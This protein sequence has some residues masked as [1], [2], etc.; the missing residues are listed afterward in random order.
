MPLLLLLLG[1]RPALDPQ[2]ATWLEGFRFSWKYFNHR[3]STLQ[4][5]P[6]SGAL[7]VAVVGGTSTTG[8]VPEALPAGCEA[9]CEEFPFKDDAL[10]HADWVRVRSERAALV[11]GAATFDVGREGAGG[12]LS[13]ALPKGARGDAV[14]VIEG[15]RLT[16]DHPLAGDEA[17][18]RPRYGWHPRRLAV[19]LGE[20]VVEDDTV[21]VDAELVFEAGA[22][23]DP[24]R[25]CIDEVVERAVVGVELT[26]R[27]VVGVEEAVA[28]P[29]ATEAAYAWSGDPLNPEEQ[30]EVPPVALEHG[31]TDP[32][33]GWSAL[34]WRFMVEE[35]GR[36]AYLRSLVFEVAPDAALGW[37][38]NYSPG[39]QLEA[40][41]YQ[42]DG[43]VR[44]FSVDGTVERGEVE[45]T[46]PAALD[47]AGDPVTH[48]LEL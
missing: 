4:L 24:D 30:P 22:T 12:T 38:N 7:G 27:F 6:S 36:G 15:L 28:L 33:L 19:V 21:S 3:V 26:V 31:L 45:A 48:A 41:D 13:A 39:T 43:T 44:A 47:E 10:L 11:T 25:T 23:E 40:F 2:D 32:A 20:P 35:P 29:V 37:A 5:E 17:C 16:T 14:A 8:E 34:D 18:Y 1:C 46:V 9:G 42:F